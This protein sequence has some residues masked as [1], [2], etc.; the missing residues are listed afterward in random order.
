MHFYKSRE[1]VVATNRRVD[2][3]APV[4]VVRK[5]FDDV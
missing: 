3:S 4:L 5:F 2:A 1:R